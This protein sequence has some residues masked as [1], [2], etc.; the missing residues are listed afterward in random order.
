MRVRWSAAGKATLVAVV[1]LLALRLLPPLLKPPE[2]PPL[3]A[4]VG[5]P[6]VEVE[7]EPVPSPRPAAS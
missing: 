6:R 3:A 4:D 2:P 7:H 1:A 5:L